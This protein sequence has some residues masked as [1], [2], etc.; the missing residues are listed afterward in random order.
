MVPAIA[1]KMG[2]GTRCVVRMYGTYRNDEMRSAVA[3]GTCGM[4]GRVG[5]SVCRVVTSARE[6]VI[7]CSVDGGACSALLRRKGK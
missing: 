1:S 6:V 3:N 7:D 2:M 4:A 5:M